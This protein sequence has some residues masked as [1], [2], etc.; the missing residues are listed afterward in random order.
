M[1]TYRLPSCL[2]TENVFCSQC[3]P[4]SGA[5]RGFPV[6]ENGDGEYPLVVKIAIENGDLVRGLTH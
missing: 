3:S 2:L 1:Y 6:S 4:S 5:M